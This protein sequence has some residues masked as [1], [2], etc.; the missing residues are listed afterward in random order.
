MKEQNLNNYHWT[1]GD[2]TK[3]SVDYL[4]S[5]FI[6]HG[7][8]ISSMKLE[9]F[10]NQRMGK[11][12][13][14]YFMSACLEKNNRKIEFN[15]FDQ[16]SNFDEFE[17]DDK[18][19]FKSIFEEYKQDAIKNCSKYVLEEKQNS[20]TN[21]IGKTNNNKKTYYDVEKVSKTDEVLSQHVIT[22]DINCKKDKMYNFWTNR[23]FIEMWTNGNVKIDDSNMVIMEQFMFDNLKYNK[24]C[25]TCKWK[26]SSWNK[27]KD[28][29]IKFEDKIEGCSVILE[30][31]NIEK[32]K[33]NNLI[34]LWENSIIKY[35]CWKFGYKIL[36]INQI[37]K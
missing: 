12:G 17:N 3:Y 2:I 35:I 37:S 16:Y 9:A 29:N 21:D 14:M 32:E 28:L 10:I 33:T 8:N 24:H 26:H 15:N 5:K 23:Q 27:Y 19:A 31:R 4:R 36:K 7:Y 1:E 25:I 6:E 18:N 11:L 20:E 13:L 22:F 30:Y 34:I